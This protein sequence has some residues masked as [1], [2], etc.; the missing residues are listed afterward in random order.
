M[1]AFTIN[2]AS[3]E[4]PDTGQVGTIA[5]TSPSNTGHASTS[6][7]VLGGTALVRKG[8]RWFA[9][10]SVS[11]QVASLTLKVDHTSDGALAGLSKSNTFR[12]QYTLNGGGAWTD[13]VNR[14]DF[15]TAQGPTTA[16][17]PLTLPQDT[18]MIQVRDFLRADTLPDGG[19]VTATATIANIAIDVVTIDPQM[20]IMM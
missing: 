3:F 11:G 6:A 4:N 20:I 5:V 17:I 14:V 1:G 10:P 9:F 18:S 13:I 2:P 8:C 19:T 12:L 15:T 16:T 7:Q